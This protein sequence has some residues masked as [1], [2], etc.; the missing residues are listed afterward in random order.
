MFA[1]SLFPKDLD[2][3]NDGGGENEGRTD[4]GGD[5]ATQE[6]GG[7]GQT[8]REKENKYVNENKRRREEKR[9]QRSAAQSRNRRKGEMGDVRP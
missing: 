2:A 6:E 8:K 7:Q 9:E 1:H 3:V 4:K 5:R